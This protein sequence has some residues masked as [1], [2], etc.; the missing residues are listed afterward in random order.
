MA[1]AA[2]AVERNGGGLLSST[3]MS[4][5]SSFTASTPFA[6]SATL[7][8]TVTVIQR[9]L[10]SSSSHLRERFSRLKHTAIHAH[11]QTRSVAAALH[12]HI[13]YVL[14]FGV[15]SSIALSLCCFENDESC[16]TDV[17]LLCYRFAPATVPRVRRLQT[18]AVA[19]WELLLPITTFIFFFLWYV[20]SP[21][22][23][24]LSTHQPYRLNSSHWHISTVLSLPSGLS[25]LSMLFGYM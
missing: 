3:S 1:A 2:L 22:E 19:I 7:Q 12:N 16:L 9:S 10:T 25:S 23:C 5:S 11:E 20:I 24:E 4:A 8:S 6:T 18:L 13:E 21:M 15:L 17:A 14:R